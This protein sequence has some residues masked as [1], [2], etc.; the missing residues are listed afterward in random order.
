MDFPYF[1]PGPRVAGSFPPSSA[2][3]D[4]G[5]FP[6]LQSLSMGRGKIGAMNSHSTSPAEKELPIIFIVSNLYIFPPNWAGADTLMEKP[7]KGE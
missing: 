3:F 1:S 4:K 6:A 7:A 5:R 2:Q